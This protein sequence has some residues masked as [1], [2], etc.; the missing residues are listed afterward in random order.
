MRDVSKRQ[1]CL[2]LSLGKGGSVG[3]RGRQ[4]E[5]GPRVRNSRAKTQRCTSQA[6]SRSV[7]LIRAEGGRAQKMK[8]LFGSRLFSPRVASALLTGALF[9]PASLWTM[10]PLRSPVRLPV[11]K[12]IGTPNRLLV[13]AGGL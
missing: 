1:R 3:Q 11:Y 13:K 5:V 2:E 4:E 7:A 9:L 10:P 8:S 6:T 12:L